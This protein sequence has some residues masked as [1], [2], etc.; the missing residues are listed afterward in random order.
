MSNSYASINNN[1]NILINLF[2]VYRVLNFKY[3]LEERNWSCIFISNALDNHHGGKRP[4]NNFVDNPSKP[5]FCI[6]CL[7]PTPNTHTKMSQN[8]HIPSIILCTSFRN[9][10]SPILVFLEERSQ[11]H[12]NCIILHYLPVVYHNIIIPEERYTFYKILKCLVSYKV[13]TNST[14]YV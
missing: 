2:K 1:S 12:A 10:I 14:K 13:T 11:Q 4:Y 9:K 8:S 3:S 7:T 5:L 6:L